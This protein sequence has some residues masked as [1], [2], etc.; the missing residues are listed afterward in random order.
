MSVVAEQALAVVN[1]GFSR[2]FVAEYGA[3]SDSNAECNRASAISFFASPFIVFLSLLLMRLHETSLCRDKNIIVH[4]DC[5]VSI[6][7][8]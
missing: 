6:K 3:Q 7:L 5:I 1:D 8:V 2:P 4:P